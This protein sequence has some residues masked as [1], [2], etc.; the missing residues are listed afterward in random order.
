MTIEYDESASIDA[1]RAVLGSCLMD[2]DVIISI[3]PILTPEDFQSGV[4][5]AIYRVMIDLYH[6]RVVGDFITIS[7]AIQR[8]GHDLGEAG[9]VTYLTG[10]MGATITPVHATYYA[11]IVRSDSLKRS[12][13]Q[14]G[15]IIQQAGGNPALSASDAIAEAQAAVSS[16][17]V[18]RTSQRYRTMQE[19]VERAYERLEKRQ[20]RLVP[21]GISDLDDKV[22]GMRP[23][24][25]IIPAARPAAGKSALVY[26]VAYTNAKAGRSVGLISLEMSGD[27]VMD[28]M[29]AFE[30]GVNMFEFRKGGMTDE[31]AWDQIGRSL[32]TLN[33]YKLAM[34]DRSDSTVADV[35]ARAR[36]MY[37]AEGIELLIVDY[38]QLMTTGAKA[39]NRVQEVSAVSRA[40]K[41]LAREL[42][43]P[44]LAPAQL[45]RAIEHRNPPIPLLSD[46]RESGSIEQ[47][48]DMVLFIHHPYWYEESKPENVAQLMV[49]KHRNGP[50]GNVDVY[51][52]ET[53]AQF[54]PLQH[55]KDRQWRVNA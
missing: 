20:E 16:I 29:I 15:K 10:L 44:V 9:G 17:S 11:G 39:E 14:A 38:L 47:D 18:N 33:E 13:I 19:A 25:L 35:M 34:D 26:Q 22:G 48:A 1:E 53:T 54:R 55:A 3:A 41:T 27:E 50:T 36:L 7:D 51:W 6:R 28:R 42:D 37:A 12:V 45:N 30:S 4:H 43:I 31:Y 49:A 23:G 5:R 2:R 24:Q 8:S 46:L 32:G 52:Q 40:M 21:F